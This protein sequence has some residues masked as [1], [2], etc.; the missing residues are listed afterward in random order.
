MIKGSII[1][2]NDKREK[3]KGLFKTW[4]K[5]SHPVLML[6]CVDHKQAKNAQVGMRRFC[7]SNPENPTIS[8]FVDGKNVLFVKQGEI[9]YIMDVI[10]DEKGILYY[11]DSS[12]SV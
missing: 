10:V 1:L 7:G 6:H 9:K 2:K 8:S 12:S 3:W 11:Y 4:Y 5:S